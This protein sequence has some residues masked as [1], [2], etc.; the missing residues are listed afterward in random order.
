MSDTIEAVV[1][2]VWDEEGNV[3]A[4]VDADEAAEILERESTGKFRR[5]LALR[6]VLPAA[7]PIEMNLSAMGDELK[8][9]VRRA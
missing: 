4:H 5:V 8:P 6:L 2:V 1:H 9:V 7:E 3:A